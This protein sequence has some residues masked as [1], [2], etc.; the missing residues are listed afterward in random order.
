MPYSSRTIPGYTAC[1]PTHPHGSVPITTATYHWSHSTACP[2]HSHYG[3][4]IHH[5][6]T[7]VPTI[8]PP[9]YPGLPH[10]RLPAIRVTI[11][12]PVVDVPSKVPRHLRHPMPR[13]AVPAIPTWDPMDLLSNPLYRSHLH[14]VYHITFLP[15][16]TNPMPPV[17]AMYL[18]DS[19]HHLYG[20]DIPIPRPRV[21]CLVFATTYHPWSRVPDITPFPCHLY[22]HYLDSYYAPCHLTPY[23]ARTTP[24]YGHTLHTV[25]LTP[26]ILRSHTRLGIPHIRSLPHK[27]QHTHSSPTHLSYRHTMLPSTFPTPCLS[28]P[29]RFT[30]VTCPTH[31]QLPMPAFC[32]PDL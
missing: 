8:S 19:S 31:T 15:W 9:C 23:L 30:W 6:P 14:T 27:P 26:I 10:P 17:T 13:P 29:H 28:F 1:T 3:S 32:A 20:L 24:G 25:A 16:F 21:Y 18:P 4:H 7:P 11:Y 2:T 5:T 12:T 22:T